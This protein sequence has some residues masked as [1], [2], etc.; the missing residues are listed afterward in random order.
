MLP[1]LRLTQDGKEHS[2]KEFLE[3]L[4][5][6]FQLNEEDLSVM[7]QSGQTTFYNRVAWA[8]TYLRQAGLLEPM[9]RGSF[10]ITDR[11]QEILKKNFTSIDVKFLQQFKEFTEFRSRK[12]TEEHQDSVSTLG[13]ANQQTPEETVEMAFRKFRQELEAELLQTLKACSPGL[14]EK[15]VV[16]VLV[17]MG[18]GGNRLDA[19]EAIG[20]SGDGG[21]DGIIK[22][23]RLGLDTIYIQAKK[24]EGSVGRPDV[25]K[26]AGALQG[27]RAKKGVLITTSSFTREAHDYVAH[28]ENKIVLIDG[29]RLA[30]LMID[31]NVGISPLERYETKKID[32]DYFEE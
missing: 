13:I 22:E 31:F 1:L 10:R 6:E 14:F 12:T 11:G 7:N 15:I 20:K 2:V 32:M 24:W 8:K 16:D 25:Q 9:K 23:D 21:I 28:L 27:M 4:A 3:P 17:K 29:Q 18:Y 5:K 30:D 19:G 26:F